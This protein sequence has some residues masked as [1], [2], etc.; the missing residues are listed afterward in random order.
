[1][2][3]LPKE[4]DEPVNSLG[5]DQRQ[6]LCLA[7]F[8]L[9]LKPVNA[10]GLLKIYINYISFRLQILIVENPHPDIIDIL[11]EVIPVYFSNSTVLIV[12][13]NSLLKCSKQFINLEE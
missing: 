12:G 10:I 8:W 13:S 6:L 2:L 4:L 3:N 7:K 1:M 5:Q 11:D 9:M